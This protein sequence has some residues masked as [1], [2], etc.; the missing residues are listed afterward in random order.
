M[1]SEKPGY[2]N[3]DRP[4]QVIVDHGIGPRKFFPCR[5]KI[6]NGDRSNSRFRQRNNNFYEYCKDASAV[7]IGRF[8]QLLRDIIY[9]A[10]NHKGRVG[11]RPRG[12]KRNQ[13]DQRVNGF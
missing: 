11:N 4:F 1:L 5:Q 12:I 10:L 9:K 13:P 2:G 8:I 6:K 3:R 7:H